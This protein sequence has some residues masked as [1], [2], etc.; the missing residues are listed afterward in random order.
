MNS[1]NYLVPLRELNLTN[2]FL[3][4][5]VM[6]DAEVHQDVLS[7]IFGRDI[8]MLEVHGTEYEKSV[9]PLARSVRLDVFSIDEE[10]R[11]YN[12]EMQNYRKSDLPKRSRYYQSMIDAGLLEPGALSYNHLNDSCI[13]LISPFDLFGYGKYCYTFEALCK[14]VQGCRLGDG[15]TRIFLNTRGT[16]DE[17]VSREL[18]DFLHY[19]ENTT[20]QEAENSGS[21]RIQR[22]HKRVCKV[23]T[24][25]EVG[26]KYMQAWEERLYDRQEAREEGL[27]EGRKE[28]IAE[29]I[30]EGIR[31]GI[32]VIIET[33]QE[34]GLSKE[35]TISKIVQKFDVPREEAETIYS[36]IIKEEAE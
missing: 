17:E 7:I 4:N 35:D 23:R 25:E 2:R 36:D 16:N 19:V 26:V 14:E 34:F 32:A 21:F 27:A 28:G 3:F 22:I 10:N 6:E 29:G 15:A 8:R 33:C 31:R 9:S 18:I 12:T 13:I 5:E 30:A 20:D 24:S 1:T 11:V